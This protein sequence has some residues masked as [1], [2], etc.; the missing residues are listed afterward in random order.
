MKKKQVLLLIGLLSLAFA[1]TGCAMFEGEEHER[2]EPLNRADW[3]TAVQTATPA[4]ATPFPVVTLPPRPTPTAPPADPATPTP[5]AAADISSANLGAE[6][7]TSQLG[8]RLLEQYPPVAVAIVI[9][10]GANI[11]H[12]PGDSYGVVAPLERGSLAGILGQNGGGDWLYAVN[13]TLARGWIARDSL[14][15]TGTLDNAPVLP[16]DPIAAALQALASAA[17]T[18]SENATDTTNRPAGR[19]TLTLEALEPVAIAKINNALANMR[20]RPGAGYAVLATLAEADEV[21][22]LALNRD[23]TWALVET[24]G[25]MWGWVSVAVLDID[26]SLSDAPLVRTL[27][28]GADYPSDQ[29]APIAGLAVASGGQAVQAEPAAAFSPV[30][31]ESASNPF[32]ALGPITAARINRTEVAIRPGPGTGFAPIDELNDDQENVS[33]L[34]IDPGG[35]WLLV[36]PEAAELGWVAAADLSLDGSLEGAPQ[37]MT[38]WVQSNGIELYNGPG[39]FHDVTGALAI[40]T[41]VQLFGLDDGR[42]WALVKPIF[43]NNAGWVPVRFLTVAGRL[44]DLP[45]APDLPAPSAMADQ[46]EIG[47]SLLPV[48]PSGESKIVVQ[49]SSGGDILV[50]DPDGT[51]LVRLTG[52]IDPALSP[53]GQTVAFTRWEGETGS[54]WLIGIDG[55]NERS[56]LDFTKQAKGPEWSPDGSN[57]VINFQQGGKLEETRSCTTVGSGSLDLPRNATDVRFGI[58]DSGDPRLCWNVPPDPFWQLRVVNLA[59]GRFEDFDGGAY[60]FRPAW[61]PG[62]PWR[63]VSDGG[64]GLV[65]VDVNQKTGRTITSEVNDSS[66]VFSPDGRY[67]AVAAGQLGGSQNYNIH[68]LNADGSGRVQLTETPLWITAGPDG[69]KAWNNVAPAWSPDGSQIAFVTDRSGRWEIWVMNIDGSNQHPLFSD[70]VNDQLQLDYDFVDERMLSWR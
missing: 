42:S 31:H 55:S 67:L 49:R 3:P 38:A 14:R 25:G 62:Q 21:S 12:G 59:D 13:A 27:D 7:L 68:R 26:G 22:V 60:A 24:A 37:V 34:G 1:A 10:D 18:G 35:Q 15:V 70:A 5:A 53:D 46:V 40:N 41:I 56:V 30:T 8:R 48:R 39:I 57:I 11:R 4:A 23:K 61:D 51:G 64:R 19:Q 28:P 16:V 17:D 50:I 63:I 45:T 9:T 69:Q 47:P 32:H 66:P 58:D 44:A 52:G 43:E 20:Q 36:Q 33:I 6:I 2:A 54:L 29:A 65:E